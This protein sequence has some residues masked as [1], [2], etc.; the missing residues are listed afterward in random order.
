MRASHIV[1]PNTAKVALSLLQSVALWVKE[2]AAGG[3]DLVG[4]TEVELGKLGHVY[5]PGWVS[6]AG[7]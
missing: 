1:C 4:G 5:L 6:A 7:P 2:C 3:Q